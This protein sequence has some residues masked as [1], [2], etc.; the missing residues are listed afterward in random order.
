MKI[1][2][3]HV[4]NYAGFMDL[5][6]EPYY[7]A[8]SV[9]NVE[10]YPEAELIAEEVARRCNCHNDLL[11]AVGRM[12][13]SLNQSGCNWNTDSHIEQAYQLCKNAYKKATQS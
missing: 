11:E 3:L 12:L 13:E 6:D 7:E 1:P 2:Q 10:D 9:L 8:K 5:K 4:I